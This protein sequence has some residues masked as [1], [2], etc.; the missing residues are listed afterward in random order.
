MAHTAKEER[1][2]LF[3]FVIDPKQRV[4]RRSVGLGTDFDLVVPAE[5]DAICGESKLA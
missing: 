5:L 1:S 2:L 3:R 4:K